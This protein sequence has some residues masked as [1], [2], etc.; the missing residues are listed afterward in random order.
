MYRLHVEWL[1]I[2]NKNWTTV[3]CPVVK[4]LFVGPR[5]FDLSSLGDP[6]RKL[7]S[8]WHGSRSHWGTQAPPT[9]TR[10]RSSGGCI[11][12]PILFLIVIDWTIQK[13]TSDKPQG[14]QWTLFTR[15]EDLYYADDLAVFSTN[16]THLQ[17]K[18]DGTDRFSRQIGLNI[19]ISRS[20]VMCINSTPH[21]HQS[22]WMATPLIMSRNLRTLKSLLM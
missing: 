7:C 15:L 19:N 18:T 12:S 21:T 9:T 10:S 11:I 5:P 22:L 20:Q 17:E 3:N 8:R 13:T 4:W 2:G 16:H 6:A 1:S 14:I